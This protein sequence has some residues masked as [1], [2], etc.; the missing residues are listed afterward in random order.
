MNPPSASEVA[1]ASGQWV[2]VDNT[3]F[4]F[5]S[6]S[7]LDK[8]SEDTII[9]KW[10]CF[11]SGMRPFL[12]KEALVLMY[13]SFS[14]LNKEEVGPIPIPTSISTEMCVEQF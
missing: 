11:F 9:T 5:D 1:V 10:R 6:C 12:S 7:Y 4:K 13:S 8:A 14:V 3:G 2:G